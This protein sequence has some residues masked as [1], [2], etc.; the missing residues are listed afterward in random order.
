[1]GSAHACLRGGVALSDVSDDGV[2]LETVLVR[3]CTP[4]PSCVTD[5]Q[6]S[7]CLS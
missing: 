4:Q 5:A 3:V 6:L 2:S 1:M 7:V